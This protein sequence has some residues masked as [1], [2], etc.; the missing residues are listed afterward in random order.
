MF[1]P[2]R[3]MITLLAATVAIGCRPDK[4]PDLRPISEPRAGLRSEVVETG[5][6]SQ[7]LAHPDL[8]DLVLLYGGETEGVL[9]PCGCTENPRGG[10]ARIHTY[11]AETRLRTPS[12]TVWMVD[13]GGFLDG[14]PED[15]G[16]ARADAT[17]TNKWMVRGYGALDPVALNVAWADL[18]GLSALDDLEGLPLVSAHIEGP[19]ITPFVRRQLGS[20]TVVFTGIARLGPDLLIPDAYTAHHA[21]DEVR[22]L[23]EA[24]VWDQDDVVV[25]L[26]HGAPV[27]AAALARDGLVDIV[28]D[29]QQH[30][31]RD[32]LHREGDAVWAKSHYQTLRLGELRLGL[33]DGRAVWALD[34]KIDLDTQIPA[35]PTLSR[36]ARQAEKEAEVVRKTVY[37]F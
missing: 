7:R 6:L 10:L 30:R 19:G 37:G 3:W 17:A 4:R 27:V 12:T 1:L 25:L 15:S 9:G 23:V 5:D 20:H 35:D 8:A 32:P 13:A 34:R 31:Y 26:A 22:A 29:A 14:T 11:A 24:G 36:W 16:V 2:S 28:I 33:Q 18:V 21:E